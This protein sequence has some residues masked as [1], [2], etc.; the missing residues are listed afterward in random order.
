MSTTVVTKNAFET[1]IPNTEI[2]VR[3]PAG[4]KGYIEKRLRG[5]V[6]LVQF[7]VPSLGPLRVDVDD[8]LSAETLEAILRE[9]QMLVDDEGFSAMDRQK[10]ADELIVRALRVLAKDEQAAATERLIR[11]FL[12]VPRPYKPKAK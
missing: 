4:T 5:N 11:L 1:Y 8:L 7:D 10:G 9:L 6:V 2:V 12:S 3:I